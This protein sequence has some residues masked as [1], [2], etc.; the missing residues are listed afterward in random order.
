MNPLSR[1]PPLFK[2]RLPPAFA[3][4]R[5]SFIALALLLAGGG[6]LSIMLN[7]HYL[8]AIAGTVAVL[9]CG[10]EAHVRLIRSVQGGTPNAAKIALHA[11][12]N[13]LVLGTFAFALLVSALAFFP[14][15]VSNRDKIR[16]MFGPTT[17]AR[18]EITRR[19]RAGQPLTSA[20]KGMSIPLGHGIELS[21]VSNDGVIT[22][23]GN[24][25]PAVVQLTPMLKP[26]K[27]G[28]PPEIVWTCTGSPARYMPASCQ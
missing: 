12:W 19:V 27:V 10:W 9:A 21:H 26:G 22:V 5:G 28:E 20:G 7:A 13:I 4:A 6:W 15:S 14:G 23:A 16:T 11:L 25:P 8:T 3:G 2:V 24:N 1:L 18:T 17:D